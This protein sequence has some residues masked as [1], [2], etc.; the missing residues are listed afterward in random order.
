[1]VIF[2]VLLNIAENSMAMVEL[3]GHGKQVM[4]L[5]FLL[6][7]RICD[8]IGLHKNAWTTSHKKAPRHSVIH[9]NTLQW[10]LWLGSKD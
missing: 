9:L 8:A 1:M 4:A 5:I 10:V 3:S 2:A 6:P 7:S